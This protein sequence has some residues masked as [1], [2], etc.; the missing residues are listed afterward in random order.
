MIIGMAMSFIIVAINM[1]LKGILVNWI[2]WIG[3]DTHST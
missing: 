2:K 3:Y 1:I